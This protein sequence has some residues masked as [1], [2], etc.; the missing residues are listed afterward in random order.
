MQSNKPQHPSAR[1]IRKDERKGHSIWRVPGD[2]PV[3][4]RLQRKELQ[5]AIGFTAQPY[6]VNEDE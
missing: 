1:P 5:A 6:Q 2:G 3:L 4:P